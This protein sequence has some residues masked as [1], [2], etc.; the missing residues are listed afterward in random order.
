MM[1][2][3]SSKQCL[4]ITVAL[5]NA[6]ELNKQGRW[7]N[8]VLATERMLKGNQ[9]LFGRGSEAPAVEV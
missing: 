7:G 9:F 6:T 8:S 2:D 3:T 4:I 1:V 5:T